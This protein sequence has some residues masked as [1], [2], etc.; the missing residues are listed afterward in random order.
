MSASDHAVRIVFCAH[1]LEGL[2][3]HRHLGDRRAMVESQRRSRGWRAM[4]DTGEAF[5]L[6]PLP[7]YD[8]SATLKPATA[9][10]VRDDVPRVCYWRVHEISTFPI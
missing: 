4:A 3:W 8:W 1:F 10:S 5:S 9:S 7:S 2:V 6:T